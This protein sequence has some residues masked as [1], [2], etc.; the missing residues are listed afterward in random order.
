MSDFCSEATSL[1]HAPKKIVA[2]SK[3]TV[4]L[5][6]IL[7]DWKRCQSAAKKF[8]DT[9]ETL[10]WMDAGHNAKDQPVWINDSDILKWIAAET[11]CKV[12]IRLSP[13]QIKDQ[14]RPWIGKQEE[15]FSSIL[16]ENMPEY[17]IKRRLFFQNETPSLLN[18]FCLLD[19]LKEYALL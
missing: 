7:L 3:G 8:C 18:H 13:Y 16:L 4:V 17:R 14:R 1:E 9:F 15:I 11:K 6:Q 2:F 12:D 19:T 10:C 5:N